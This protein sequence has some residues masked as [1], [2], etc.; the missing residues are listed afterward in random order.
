MMAHEGM[1]A[2]RRY[3]S[4]APSEPGADL[5]L[6]AEP[7]AA[8]CRAPGP[9]DAASFSFPVLPLAH[10]C[11]LQAPGR[12]AAYPGASTRSSS[13]ASA[14]AKRACK[15]AAGSCSTSNSG[16]PPAA[17][18]CDISPGKKA[19]GEASG[20]RARRRLAA[21]CSGDAATATAALELASHS[22]PPC[23]RVAITAIAGGAGS[24]AAADAAAPPGPCT[25]QR[26]AQSAAVAAGGEAVVL[27]PYAQLP[28]MTASTKA[29]AALNA[30][31]AHHQM[32]SMAH[33]NQ[34]LQ[35]TRQLGGLVTYPSPYARGRSAYKVPRGEP[36][37]APAGWRDQIEGAMVNN[38]AGL[39]HPGAGNDGP[40]ASERVAGSA[41]PSSAHE[42]GE[43]AATQAMAAAR[44]PG[45]GLRL[46]AAY[47]RRGC[48]LLVLEYSLRRTR[49]GLMLPSR[50]Q[51]PAQQAHAAAV[52]DVEEDGPGEAALWTDGGGDDDGPTAWQPPTLS[53]QQ[54]TAAFG[55]ELVP[56]GVRVM[57]GGSGGAGYGGGYGVLQTLDDGGGGV[58][59]TLDDVLAQ[60]YQGRTGSETQW[61][62]AQAGG[63]PA[64]APAGS[65]GRGAADAGEE[66]N[67]SAWGMAEG[68]AAAP[69]LALLGAGPCILATQPRQPPVQLVAL[70]RGALAASASAVGA[71][72]AKQPQVLARYGGGQQA[73]AR[74]AVHVLAPSAADA[75]AGGVSNAD[76]DL[77]DA[78]VARPRRARTSG[79]GAPPLAAAAAPAHDSAQGHVP[80]SASASASAR[81]AAAGGHSEQPDV[82]GLQVTLAPCPNPGLLLLELELDPERDAAASD[83]TASPSRAAAAPLLSPVLPLVV[84]DSRAVQ[85]EINCLAAA[86]AA[87]ARTPEAAAA[88]DAGGSLAAAAAVAPTAA[89]FAAASLPGWFCS[90]IYDFGSFLDLLRACRTAGQA[91]AAA[92]A[93]EGRWAGSG[94]A[95]MG[96]RAMSV[97]SWLMGE[98]EALQDGATVDAQDGIGAATAWR[99]IRCASECFDPAGEER[100]GDGPPQDEEEEEDGMEAGAAA[101]PSGVPQ[102]ARQ[103]WHRPMTDGGSSWLSSAAGDLGAEEEGDVET[104]RADELPQPPQRELWAHAGGALAPPAPPCSAEH[105]PPPQA[106]PAQLRLP[107]NGPV[108]KSAPAAAAVTH[109]D[110]L[111]YVAAGVAAYACRQGLAA[112]LSYVLDAMC[113]LG[114][115]FLAAAASQLQRKP[116]ATAAAGGWRAGGLECVQLGG[117][118]ETARPA[119]PPDAAHPESE[120]EAEAA[121]LS[122]SPL[123]L[124]DAAVAAQW[125][126]LGLGQLAMQSGST[127]VLTALLMHA[128][129]PDGGSIGGAGAGRAAPPPAAVASLG[130]GQECDWLRLAALSECTGLFVRPGPGGLTALHLAA[131]LQDRPPGH[132]AA[133]L[134][135]S[136]C[137]LAAHAWFEVRD[138]GCLSAAEYALR[139]GAAELNEQCRELLGM[140]ALEAQAL[141]DAGGAVQALTVAALATAR[142]LAA[143]SSAPM[144]LEAELPLL[145]DPAQLL[146]RASAASLA[147]MAGA[148]DAGWRHGSAG[149][150]PAAS[151]AAASR[152]SMED[153]HAAAAAAQQQQQRPELQPPQQQ[154]EQG[155][156]DQPQQP[157]AAP[158]LAACPLQPP[159]PAQRQPP[160]AARL[161]QRL[162]AA[163]AAT[164]WA[165][166]FRGFADLQLEAAFQQWGGGLALSRNQ[167]HTAFYLLFIASNTYKALCVEGLRGLSLII[168]LGPGVNILGPL[169][170]SVWQLRGG[171]QHDLALAAATQAR[172][173]FVAA[174]HLLPL[175]HPQ[176]FEVADVV[177]QEALTGLHHCVI[178]PIMEQPSTPAVVL[179]TIVGNRSMEAT[180]LRSHGV[181]GWA[182]LATL[183][184]RTVANLV[185]WYVLAVWS[186][187][188]FMAGVA[189][190]RA[191]AA[192]AA[193]DGRGCISRPPAGMLPG[194][195]S[196]K[197]RHQY[198]QRD[199]DPTTKKT[200]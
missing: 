50:R 176:T 134:V 121:L 159:P 182:V 58:S 172:N 74:C 17:T 53:Q 97:T 44:G 61:L 131:L 59:V 138:G 92:A 86:A 187:M 11:V 170:V 43:P 181:P 32:P 42:G 3:D 91:P 167:L 96:V 135:L 148:L 174:A 12:T 78:A 192:A 156:R 171:L 150:S 136:L 180:M 111:L 117:G 35:L 198:A 73:P 26:P 165:A 185:M 152:S 89:A 24:A 119:Y 160:P 81:A 179:L 196:S 22:Q 166:P 15:P 161:Q 195:G 95:C 102:A 101:G 39:E 108:S 5:L 65:G 149:Y 18:L 199:F 62:P 110:E 94:G 98:G 10:P 197:G 31:L 145:H 193:A 33:Y 47:L 14:R 48:I 184:G 189:R 52:E 29:G 9:D 140:E 28:A 79:P 183:V 144:L 106:A 21:A 158:H 118:A 154:G 16:G 85:V 80:Q 104:H 194:P 162:L 67:A 128:R 177:M 68:E 143:R 51:R 13:S 163:A 93:G 173:V 100:E 38:A 133:Q 4:G 37:D 130:P 107:D 83:A 126:G 60:H 132:E 147:A 155:E 186:R 36:S 46:D 137:P 56:P 109:A 129:E 153:A 77:V 168:A 90:F 146:H 123:L 76:D 127:D 72:T 103:Q 19:G 64:A 99:V 151:S 75:A 112:T 190:R 45:G 27:A 55:A 49:S 115:A 84:V 169:A 40:D 69:A 139:V 122:R 114:P 125:G 88:H 164:P 142:A 1:P 63:P 8:A 2:Y 120:S 141:G 116:A 175:P 157:E 188:S 57:H 34:A 7:G 66:A 178:Q 200:N 113:G 82:V 87:A 191:A 70:A 41:S 30:N 71:G 105:A 23:I 6:A 20:A 54:L 124:L 25:P